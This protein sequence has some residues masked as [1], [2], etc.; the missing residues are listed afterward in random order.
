MSP[1]T[2]PDARGISGRVVAWALAAVLIVVVLAAGWI[3]VRGFLAY[4]H[5]T[6]AQDAAAEVAASLD[7]PTT[8]GEAIAGISADT[9]AARSLT[10]DPIWQAAE[11]LPWIGPQLAAV[12]TVTAAVDDVA[13]SALTPLAEVASSFS[14]DAIRPRDGSVDVSLFQTL[15]PAAREGA[16]GIGAAAASVA[17][18]DTSRLLGPLRAPVAEAAELLDTTSAGAETLARATELM[19]AMLG[20]DGPRNYLVIFQN[21]AEW[22]SQGGIVG[23]MAVIA[24]D[25]GRMSL[26]AQGSSGDFERYPEPVVPF[27]PDILSVYGERPGLY[28]QNATQVA[29]FALT[30]QIAKEMWAREFGTQVDG[31]ISIDPVALSYLLEATGPITLPTGDVLTSE[32]AV[33]LL[34]N[35]VYQRYS[36]PSDQDVFFEVAAAKIFEALASGAAE[37]RP[38]LEALTQASEERRLILW[39]ARAEDQAVLDGTSLQG[40]LPVTD[41]EQTAFGVYLNDG[42]GS[43]MDYYLAADTSVGWCTGVDGLSEAGL[44]VTVR[45]DAPADAASLPRYITGGGSFGV[46]EGS[47]RTLTYVYLPTG[48]SLV[49]SEASNSAAGTVFGGGFDAGRQVVSWT[50]ELAPG[51]EATLIVRVATPRTPRLNVNLS[52]TVNANETQEFATSCDKA[53]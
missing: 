46:P 19:P 13:S 38:L 8:A 41:A 25:G 22:R 29:D 34:L 53:G 12:S 4:G 52:P 33:D 5:L 47:A 1:S 35:G 18:I 45:N 32:N 11:S 39:S 26:A 31:V 15:Q 14:V 44:S 9:S 49:S 23:A 36:E 3:G 51:E 40:G 2:P 43:K 17:A 37:P 6:D 20:A 42:T 30:G 16:D 48:A 28:I 27:S 21:N 24:T 7:D 10:S 50:T